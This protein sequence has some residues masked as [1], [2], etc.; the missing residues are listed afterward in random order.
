MKTLRVLVL[1][2]VPLLLPWTLSAFQIWQPNAVPD[3][4]ER[5]LDSLTTLPSSPHGL[6]AGQL[7]DGVLVIEPV[8]QYSMQVGTPRSGW[9]LVGVTLLGSVTGFTVGAILDVL[10]TYST[11]S[12]AGYAWWFGG[13]ML[14]LGTGLTVATCTTRGCHWRL[15]SGPYQP[16]PRPW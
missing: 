6:F 13:G 4:P 2:Q 11:G 3:H 1:L 15:P 9:G 14:A 7:T 10:S 5:A 8:R 16:R 12:S